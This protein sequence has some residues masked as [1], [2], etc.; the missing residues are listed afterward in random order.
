MHS[1]LHTLTHVPLVSILG[2]GARSLHILHTQEVMLIAW[3]NAFVL[4]RPLLAAYGVSALLYVFSS[5]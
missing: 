4:Q 2:N 3:V 5:S 1:W